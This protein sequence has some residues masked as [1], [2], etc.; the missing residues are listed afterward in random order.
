MPGHA[1]AA[2]VIPRSQ[3]VGRPRRPG[4]GGALL[5]AALCVVALALVWVV[6]ELVPAAHVRDAVALHDFVLLDG[7]HIHA[8]TKVLL[9][10]LDPLLFTIWGLVLVLIALA[11]GR[12]R[13][14]LAVVV[15]MALAP[16]SSE[17]LKPLLAHPHVRIGATR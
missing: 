8:V 2:G 16:L 12:T 15:V 3:S 11:R 5:L 17:V 14:A 9:H 1:Y 10:L 7:P 6:A 13:V 4:A